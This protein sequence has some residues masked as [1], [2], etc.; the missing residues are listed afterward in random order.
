[1]LL[2]ESLWI[3]KCLEK[4]PL[5]SGQLCLN[6]A[7]STRKYRTI[8]QPYIDQNIFRPLISRGIK[9]VHVDRKADEG[10]DLCLD[11]TSI[12]TSV[13]P[14]VPQGDLVLCTSFLEHVE[15]REFA[16]SQIKSLTKPGGYILISVP[17]FFGYH[18]DPIDTMYRPSDKDLQKYYPPSEFTI[19]R[20]ETI[21]APSWPT[22]VGDVLAG[23]PFVGFFLRKISSRTRKRLTFGLSFPS[24]VALLVVRKK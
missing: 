1:M 6:L 13:S 2:E 17:R 8:D 3:N 21:S 7:S 18:R 23:Y 24:R 15:N 16:N 10:V 22:A 14:S 11:I 5:L 4:I 12:E 9:V 20:S 19:I